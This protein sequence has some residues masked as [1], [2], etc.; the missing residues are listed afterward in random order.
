MSMPHNENSRVKIPVILHLMRLGYEY[1]SLK[2][3]D[4]DTQ[5]N[6]FPKLF[7]SSLCRINPD[8]SADDAQRV[9]NDIK[10]EL[11][12]EDLGKAFYERLL[13]QSSVKLIDF[14][15]FERNSFHVLTELPYVNGD[16]SFRPDITLLINGMPLIFV[17]VKKPNN[18]G[19]IGEERERMAKRALNP[20][21]RRFINITQLMIFSNNM[22][23]QEGEIEPIQGV[24]YATSAY[25]KPHFNFFR[26]EHQGDMAKW[27]AECPATS[28]EQE[29]LVLDDNH[30]KSIKHS[31]EFIEN[32]RFDTPTN[33]ICTSLLSRK[34]LAFILRYGLA[35]VKTAQGVEKHIM[36]YP[37]IFAT[38]AI[39]AAL[40]AGTRKGII[41][42]TQGSGKTALAYYN[43]R[44]LTDY[45]AK[46]GIVPK[47]YFI[48]DRLDLLIQAS[49]EFNSRGL[50]VHNIDS[51][52]DFLRDLQS[53]QTQHN[54][55]GK[56]EITVVNIQKF[57][58][59]PEPIRSTDYDLNVQ[60]IYFL[61]E[62]HRSYNPTGSFLANLQQSDTQAIKIGLTGTPLIASG[63]G[64]FNSRTIFGDY[65]H[66]YYY[67]SSIADGYTLRLIREAIS[68]EYQMQ[69][70]DVLANLEIAKG[71]LKREEL[72]AH[73][74]LVQPMLDYIIDNFQNTRKTFADNSI[75]AMIICDSNQ[76]A[77]KMFEY[78][79]SQY[80]GSLKAALILHDVGSKEERKAE[81]DQFKDGK[82]DLLFVYNMLLTGF[83]APRLKKLYLGRLIKAHNLLQALTRV[84]RTYRDYRY[85]YVVDFADIS[86]EFDKTNRAY[87]D[88]LQSELGDEMQHYSELFKSS[89]EIAQDIS[90]IKNT[91]FDFDCTNA[92]IFCQQISAIQDK[93]QVLALK[94]AL[95]N[96][97][98]LYNIIRLQGEY[99]FLQQLDFEK[100]NL[101]YRETAAHLDT[102]NLRENMAQGNT[103]HLLNEALE[104]VYFQFVKIGEHELKLADDLKNIM[105]QTRE[106]LAQNFDQEDPEFISLRAELERIF[107]KKNLSEVSLH[108]M[109]ENIKIL[110][111]VYAQ[112]RALNERNNR[113]RHKYHGDPKFVR[114]HKRLM[115]YAEFDF[116]SN[117][118]KVFD[119]LIN[120]K[121]IADQKV[122]D[123]A[124]ILQN[125]NYFEREMQP[126]I[127]RQFMVEQ[128]L[129]LNPTT[130]NFI[131]Q[132]LV[133]EY[134]REYRGQ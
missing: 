18:K 67:N 123:L 105:R 60:R 125:E 38:Q 119:A 101:L 41:W 37:Q 26:E 62:V 14:E 74:K 120:I 118:Q 96:A 47:F 55:S 40:N 21:F 84:N 81:I 45:F 113:L 78:H 6:I 15:H 34:R 7:I 111:T 23:Y 35:Y 10:L 12:N 131:N 43:V 16:E 121:N 127:I 51:R 92:E 50:L 77:K 117:K 103:S 106:S 59:D 46:Q 31:P 76:Q 98:N 65:I 72:Y 128:K 102:L 20:K 82:I 58:D 57:Q 115:Q 80:S 33:C 133:K 2:N 70:Q 86:A 122:F 107:K 4:W 79:Q 44:H 13:N 66:K 89:E 61:D 30:L 49:N 17:E 25:G 130:A 110:E 114:V 132:L 108:E 56:A 54:H 83:D 69:L 93:E 52:A 99:E 64:K 22:P 53:N 39:Q 3:H 19:G 97:K 8:L 27:I 29:W 129:S 104:D 68:T 42:H 32:K 87:W 9:L 95:Q 91:L 109:P 94:K 36:R 48:V 1:L 88:E 124:Q 24:F 73:P 71:S 100:L 28:A 63:E 75:G 112:I 85:G 126:E 11:D 90:N 5:T 116:A 134:L